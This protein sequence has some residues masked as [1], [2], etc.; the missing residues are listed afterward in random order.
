ML[1]SSKILLTL[2][3]KTIHMSVHLQINHGIRQNKYKYLPILSDLLSIIIFKLIGCYA[4]YTALN[5]ERLLILLLFH[6]Y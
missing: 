2:I 1:T 4:L 6:A 3:K 5:L